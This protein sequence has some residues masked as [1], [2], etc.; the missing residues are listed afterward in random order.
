MAG[1][2][3][4]KWKGEQTAERDQEAAL[5]YRQG[6]KTGNGSFPALGQ[7]RG[8]D[9]LPYKPFNI[10]STINGNDFVKFSVIKIRKK[11]PR[12]VSRTTENVDH[13]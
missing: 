10:L 3:E 6:W 13:Y 1:E 9:T 2:F 11:H 8:T 4:G 7:G 12:I 5:L